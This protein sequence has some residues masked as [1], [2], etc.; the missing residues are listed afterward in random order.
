MSV[1]EREIYRDRDRDRERE[2]ERERERSVLSSY[3]PVTV[4]RSSVGIGLSADRLE[5]ENLAAA[6]ISVD[7][8]SHFG[9]KS[10][11]FSSPEKNRNFSKNP[12]P[13]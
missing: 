4:S 1:F 12:G 3:P 8:K 5:T 11:N 2:R 10:A 9:L 13:R 6:G 7:T